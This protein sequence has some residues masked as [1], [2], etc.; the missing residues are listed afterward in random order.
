MMR[1]ML[2]SA[3]FAYILARQPAVS[4]HI[5]PVKYDERFTQDPAKQG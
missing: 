3:E 1:N 4:A 5:S 2:E